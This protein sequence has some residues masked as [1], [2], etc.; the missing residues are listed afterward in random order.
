[1]LGVVWLE[2]GSA[3]ELASYLVDI[4]GIRMIT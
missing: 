2:G 4:V 1:M 3:G